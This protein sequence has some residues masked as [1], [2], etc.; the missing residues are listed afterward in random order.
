M[1][2]I[3]PEVTV[4]AAADGT[5]TLLIDGTIRKLQAK[6]MQG[7][8]GSALDAIVAEVAKPAGQPVMITA[9]DPTG[10]YRLLVDVDGT[11][12]PV[13]DPEPA[14]EPEPE[15][16][17]PPIDDA[18][19]EPAEP[20]DVAPA[21]PVDVAPTTAAPQPAP[22]AAA[23]A[24]ASVD[25]DSPE[26]VPGPQTRREARL[27]ARDFALSRPEAKAAPAQEGWQGTVNRLGAGLFKVAPGPQE[28]AR[29][30]R[31][32]SVQRGIAGH[33]TVVVIGEKG[34]VSKTT[35]TY[36]LS[37]VLGRVRGGTILAWDNNEYNGSLGGRSYE[38][39]HDHTARDL[40]GHIDT[41]T[42]QAHQADL[43]NFVR[44]QR[45]NKFDVLASQN[46]L[47]NVRVV[48]EDEF[49]KLYKALTR[50]YRLIIVDT[51]NNSE[52]STWRAAVES[53]DQLVLTTS[54][55]E[56]ASQKIASLA[57][58]LDDNGFS[59]KLAN[60]VTLVHHTSTIDY[61]E[62]EQRIVEHMGR[63][64]RALV[65]LPFD[66]A[67]DGGGTIEWDVLSD[68]SREAWLAATA[69]V[70]DGLR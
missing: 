63:R 30:D 59:D 37:A 9:N 68:E 28:L 25:T 32:N 26:G 12:T 7:V 70:I 57:D 33:K 3:A 48:E 24:P 65:T 17:L 1:T 38:A 2:T 67:L 10:S 58:K 20:A 36:L 21:A 56:D 40:L 29:R 69:A 64:T 52:A 41:F 61:P 66:K 51:G 34:G 4:T 27:T 15:Q 35:S 49:R 19:A 31:R 43:V 6:D 14:P 11:V 44:P 53:A 47:G 42:E 54:V 46:V 22:A 45:D 62:L 60:A 55:K 13:A 39:H 16:P 18:P 5:G 50:F 8:V 23:V